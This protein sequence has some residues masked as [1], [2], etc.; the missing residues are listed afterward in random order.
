MANPTFNSRQSDLDPEAMRIGQLLENRRSLLDGPQV[1]KDD[2]IESM[3]LQGRYYG[4]DVVQH[5]R[6]P[7]ARMADIVDNLSQIMSIE[8]INHQSNVA[9]IKDIDK[10]RFKLPI[11]QRKA[12]ELVY[13]ENLPISTA[14][15]IM[16]FT[17]DEV[18]M[19]IT[20]AII[21]LAEIVR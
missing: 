20:Q 21:A 17:P 10:K 8:K 4:R 19:F 18:G 5:S 1:T 6:E 14:S 13:Y 3:V 16:G 7:D 11:H 15:R 12:V 9:T 2:L